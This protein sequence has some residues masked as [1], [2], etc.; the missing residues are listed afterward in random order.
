VSGSFEKIFRP[1]PGLASPNPI[2]SEDRVP[3]TVEPGR[4]DVAV[5]QAADVLRGR[6][7]GRGG[8][9]VRI[10][11]A[12]QAGLTDG[13]D[14][15]PD[16]AIIRPVTADW[17]AVASAD[18][19]EWRVPDARAN[20]GY[21]LVDAPAAVT[22]G[23]LAAAD[24]LALLEMRGIAFAPL[25]RED[26]T[27]YD[28]PGYDP[29]T[30]LYLDRAA[31]IGASLPNAP[32]REDA[33]ES[34][35]AILDL[36]RN[37][38]VISEADRAVLLSAAITAAIRPMLP[39]APGHGLD[40]STAGSGKSMGCSS[41]GLVA[42]GSLPAMF[43]G[44]DTAEEFE[45]RLGSIMLAGDPL[46]CLDNVSRPLRGD[47]LCQMLSERVV[48]LRPLGASETVKIQNTAFFVANGNNMVLAEDVNRRML[49]AR[50]DPGVERPELRR[51][52]QNLLSEADERRPEFV[53]HVLTIVAAH[54]RAGSPAPSEDWAELAVCRI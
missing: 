35:R 4:L 29:E 44:G 12:A 18:L 32:D 54:R 5:R 15:P 51:F 13:V 19:I 37:M 33:A 25:L 53:S 20:C 10:G 50:L 1:A 39:Q 40:S 36:F 30:G 7:Y 42:T 22:R 45:K 48:Q 46:V 9:A 17:L 11:K 16:Q 14:R 6:V 49:V 34:C 24:D 21:R 38:P 43:S 28:A 31:C 47:A 26:G 27:L 23:L 8:Q 41:F 3:I 52:D 2:R